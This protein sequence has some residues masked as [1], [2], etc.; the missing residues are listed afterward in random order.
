MQ[1]SVGK[2]M[3][4]LFWDQQG[5]PVE[6]YT[7]KGITVTSAIYC[8]LLRYHMRPAIRPKCHGLLSADVLLQHYNAGHYTVH[9][10]AVTTEDMQ[11]ECLP[12]PPHL[13][14]LTPSDYYIF[15][16]LK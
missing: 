6:H 16:P 2:V 1:A 10:T 9:V 7:S 8:D 5:P 13:P 14:D 15:G 3:L 12:H 4:T 11:Y